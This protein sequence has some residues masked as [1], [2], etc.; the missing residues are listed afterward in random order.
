MVKLAHD[1]CMEGNLSRLGEIHVDEEVC[2]D[3]PPQVEEVL[4]WST[5]LDKN[6]PLLQFILKKLFSDIIPFNENYIT[7]NFLTFCHSN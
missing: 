2:P 4:L 1:L 6:G 3:P 5:R 7:P